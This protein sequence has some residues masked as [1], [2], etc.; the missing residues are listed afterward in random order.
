MRGCLL[1]N[2]NVISSQNSSEDDA[3]HSVQEIQI[4]SF[5]VSSILQVFMYSGHLQYINHN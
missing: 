2:K 3:F 5:R 1:K 4:L